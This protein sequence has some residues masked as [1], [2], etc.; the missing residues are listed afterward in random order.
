MEP[1]SNDEGSDGSEAL[2]GSARGATLERTSGGERPETEVAPE[3]AGRE[4][5]AVAVAAT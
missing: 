4:G 2:T 3:K 1:V 5:S